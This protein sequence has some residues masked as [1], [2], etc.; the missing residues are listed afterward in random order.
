VSQ[1]QRPHI[2]I[3]GAGFA[4]LQVARELARLLPREE[5]GRITLVDQNNFMLFTPMLTEVAGGEVPA[6][7]VVS[8]V[9]R[10]SPRVTFLQGRVDGIDL[11]TKRVTLTRGDTS[12]AVPQDQRTL[13]A[14]QLVIALGSVTNFHGV[15]GVEEHARTIKS[16][17][18]AA[19]IRNRAL[20]LLEYAAAE[21]AAAK[22]RALLTFVVAGGGFSGVETMAALNGLARGSAKNYP[23]I[24]EQDIRTVLVHPGKRLLPELSAGLAHYA[25]RKLRQRGVEVILN[26]KIT[27]AGPDY[28]ELEGG[29]RITT[30]LLIWTAG[31]TPSPVIG[32]LD[33]KRGHHGG[34]IVDACCAVP[35]H[36]G[37]WALG[38]CAEVPR[39]GGQATYAPTAQNATREGTQVAR[40][41]VVMLHGQEPR[42]FVYTPIGEFALVGRRAGV[43]SLYGVPLSGLAAWALWRGIYLAKAPLPGKRVRIGLDW[44]LDVLFGREIVELPLARST[45]RS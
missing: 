36:P 22:R 27:R 44:L 4:G 24:Q 10:L 30:Y 18:D 35:G 19:A 39:P 23:H 6:D 45:P 21:P 3:L 11:A 13:E 14:D 34:I 1:A 17:G 29:H 43:A 25:Q 5:D 28:A 16:V 2:V 9:R 7:H 32:S 15:S 37:V 26:T 40:N 31:V 20:Q 33:A 8:A 42:P 38:D 41:I 12:D